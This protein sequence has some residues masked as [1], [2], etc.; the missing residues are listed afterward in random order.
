MRMAVE[1]EHAS[2][3][4]TECTLSFQMS[5][6]EKYAYYITDTTMESLKEEWATM[7]SFSGR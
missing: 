3:T 6:R 4:L 7:A 5:H 1:Y 2:R